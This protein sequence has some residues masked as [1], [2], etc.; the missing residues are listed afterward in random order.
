M[1]FLPAAS[2]LMSW[3]MKLPFE[4]V[5]G[6]MHLDYEPRAWSKPTIDKYFGFEKA[7]G[8]LGRISEELQ[9]LRT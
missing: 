1:D 3:A 6:K 5:D 9:I 4:F 8:D 7:Y 2:G